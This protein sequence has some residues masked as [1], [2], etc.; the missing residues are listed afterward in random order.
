VI[1]QTSKDKLQILIYKLNKIAKRYNL[2]ISGK[3]TRVIASK[4][5]I[6]IRSKIVMNVQIL[7]QISI[8]PACC[9]NK[10]SPVSDRIQKTGLNTRY[11]NKIGT[12]DKLST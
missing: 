7:E 8:S 1:P 11:H 2:K 5:K 10:I 4:G 12:A 3:K 9:R 6:P